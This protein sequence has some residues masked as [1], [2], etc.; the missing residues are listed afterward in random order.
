LAFCIGLSLTNYNMYRPTRDF[1]GL[2]NYEEL[3]KDQVFI[4][5]LANTAYYVIFTVV[6]Y[7]VLGFLMAV[8]LN[9]KLRGINIFRTVF[10]FP[11]VVDWVIISIVWRFML[12]PAIGLV[13]QFLT[14]QGFDAQPF[15]NSPQQAMPIIIIMSIWKSA[16]YYAIIYLAGLQ[17][18]PQV[19]V[20]QAQIDGANSWQVL[21]HITLPWLAP[22]TLFVIIIASINSLRVFSQV[23][24]LTAGGPLNSTITVMLYLYNVSFRYLRMGYGSAV[25]VVFSLVVLLLVIIQRRVLGSG[26]SGGAAA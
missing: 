12:E 17:D 22:V 7:T 20:E 3:L 16:A 9:Q 6:G 24:I 10:Y 19:L 18:V 23:Y 4:T 14:A 21:R 1:I 11:V 15:F 26:S 5:S 8:L 25:A 13:N 2:G